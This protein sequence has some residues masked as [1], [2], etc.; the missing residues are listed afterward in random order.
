MTELIINSSWVEDYKNGH[1]LE[2]SCS[3][4]IWGPTAL[5]EPDILQMK[6]RRFYSQNIFFFEFTPYAYVRLTVNTEK[7]THTELL[8]LGR[9]TKLHRFP[10]VVRHG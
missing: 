1:K 4:K 9:E 3:F 8:G 7:Q 5:C 6:S 2:T 10:L